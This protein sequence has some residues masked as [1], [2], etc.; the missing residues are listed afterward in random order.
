MGVTMG[1]YRFLS[2][3]L[4]RRK[5]ISKSISTISICYLL[6]LLLFVSSS[7]YFL[8]CDPINS[9]VNSIQDEEWVYN[10][11]LKI[12]GSAGV[13]NLC[14][15]NARVTVNDSI[16]YFSDDNGILNID[17]LRAGDYKLFVEHAA[18]GEYIVSRTITD[19]SIILLDILTAEEYFPLHHGNKWIYE[20]TYYSGGPAV[21]WSYNR[22]DG[23]LQWDVE[24]VTISDDR[25]EYTIYE[26][27]TGL[28]SWEIYN[29]GEPPLTGSEPI[30]LDNYI[31]IYEDKNHILTAGD[32]SLM[33]GLAV[34]QT[35]PLR[36]YY[37][38]EFN[39]DSLQSGKYMDE[40]L[41]KMK[42]GIGFT[43]IFR[44]DGYH[45]I[46]STSGVLIDY[47]LVE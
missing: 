4:R 15:D 24:S 43:E 41:V 14:G 11:Q 28:K 39:N 19:S 25:I 42:K 31:V 32:G 34:L 46:T 37:N 27:M 6:S 36:R 9:P 29:Y 30:Y 13:V 1:N 16:T 47:S 20:Y 23:T 45:M 5:N 7:F 10:I 21:N 17:S 33:G 38:P 22:I 2:C 40:P 26:S 8:G 3:F 44:K 12:I 35:Y 18:Y